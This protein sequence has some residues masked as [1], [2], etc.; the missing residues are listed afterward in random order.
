MGKLEP[1]C[2]AWKYLVTS[3][4]IA[5]ARIGKRRLMI[6]MVLGSGSESFKV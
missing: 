5:E 3:W 4:T 1:Y 6:G 2:P